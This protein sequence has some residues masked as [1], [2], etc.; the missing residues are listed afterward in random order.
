MVDLH[1]DGIVVALTRAQSRKRAR[2]AA[3]VEVADNEA[4]GNEVIGLWLKQALLPPAFLCCFLRFIAAGL[5]PRNENTGNNF[6]CSI[7]TELNKVTYGG[8]RDTQERI[9]DTKESISE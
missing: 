3:D 8:T 9:R 2:R 6:C 7:S 4:A 1:R 5:W